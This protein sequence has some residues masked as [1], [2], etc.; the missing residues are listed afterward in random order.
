MTAKTPCPRVIFIRHGQTEWSKSG[1]HTS[2]TDIPL[3][4]FGIKQMRNTGKALIGNSPLNMIKP[5]NLTH[6]FV[7]PRKRAQQTCE[8]ILES[9]DENCKNLLKIET[10]QNIREWEYGDY[11]GL[12]TQEIRDS[13]H[14]RKIDPPTRTWNIWRDGCEN[15]E[16]YLDVTER[17]DEFIKKIQAIH[18]KSL[19]E[20]KP[21]DVI[22]IAHGHIL[23]C[24]VTR[25]VRKELNKDPMLMIDAGGVGV[26]SYQH[27]NVDEP[28]IYL[29][30]AFT[31]PVEEEGADV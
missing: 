8:L 13:R 3:T 12:K 15:G 4:E 21:S 11:E 28:S 9:L 29:A 5:Q 20:D 7:S 24:L 16:N 23:R 31:V 14:K 17:L 22:V 25:W 26:L 10:D 19:E 27:H 30:G 18:A 6:I 1:Q 2:R